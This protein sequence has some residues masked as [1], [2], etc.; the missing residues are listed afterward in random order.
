MSEIQKKKVLL[1]TNKFPYGIVETFIEAELEAV[2]ENIDL[3][4]IPTQTHPASDQGRSVPKAVKVDN[5][6]NNR[7]KYEYPLKAFQMMFSRAFRDEVRERKQKERVTF[8]DRIHLI[9]Y[10]GRAKQIADVVEAKYGSESV[11]LYSYWATEASYAEMLMK[12][13]KDYKSVTR[14][15]G[16]DVYDGHCAYGVIP[17]QR[18]AIAGIDRVYVCS[19]D[20]RDYLRTKYPESK[21]RITYSYLGTRD[22]GFKPGD[23]RSDEF[24]IASCS[25]LVPVKRVHLLA[26][27]LKS[28]TDMKIHWIHIGDGAEREKIEVIA[29]TFPDNIRV[30]FTGNMPHDKVMEYYRDHDVNLFINVSESEGLP[31]SI[32]EVVSFG[33][34]V[35]ATDVGGTGEVVDRCIGDLIPKGFSVEELV[36]LIRKFADMDTTIYKQLRDTTRHFWEENYSA[37]NNYKKFYHEITD[38]CSE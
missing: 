38:Q 29:K 15:H 6:F 30:T 11:V 23:N 19:R 13:R 28:I 7:P 21:D 3:T 37:A 22:Y 27:T 14:A 16:T 20:G 2:P 35:V 18:S 34:P 33:I 1:L 36:A 4:I 8:A 17:G 9:G 25:R 24:V 26:E 5:V 32:M 10:F 31:V 12:L